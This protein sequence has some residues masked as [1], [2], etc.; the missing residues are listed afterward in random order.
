MTINEI[1]AL[2]GVS[3]ATVS[4]YLNQGYVSEEKREKIR[5]VIEETG[6][7]PM[8]QAQNLRSRKTKLIGIVIPKINSDTVSR[9]VAGVTE[10]L[11]K[12]NYQLLLGN[13]ANDVN[14]ELRLLAGDVPD[15]TGLPGFGYRWYFIQM[16]A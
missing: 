11:K 12:S 9:M 13:A 5:R 10:E 7:V 8:A 16:P 6:Y 15:K 1:A 3:R 2:S 14:E 4:R